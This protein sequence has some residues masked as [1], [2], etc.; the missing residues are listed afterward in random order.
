MLLQLLHLTRSEEQQRLGNQPHSPA[1]RQSITVEK[2][3]TAEYSLLKGNDLHTEE[4]I[5]DFIDSCTNQ[6]DALEKERQQIRNSNRRPKTPED[7]LEKNQAARELSKKL[8]PLRKNLQLTQTALEHY[9]SVW[10]LLQAERETE[11]KA[12]IKNR[13]RGR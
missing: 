12:R 1:I 5:L 11:T 9:P 3:L 2:Q 10:E 7:R 4:N 13:E 8:K 6:I